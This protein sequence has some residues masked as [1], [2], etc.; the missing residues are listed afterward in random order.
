M[1]VVLVSMGGWVES[2]GGACAMISFL[3]VFPV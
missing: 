1:W 3:F 2:V